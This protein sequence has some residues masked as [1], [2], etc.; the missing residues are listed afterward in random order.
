MTIK[1]EV[2]FTEFY[3]LNRPVFRG[4]RYLF[5]LSGMMA[6]FD[7]LDRSDKASLDSDWRAVGNDMR[8]VMNKLS[9]D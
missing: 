4:W 1:R 9:F 6:D 2:P 5:N 7:F 3:N 8:D